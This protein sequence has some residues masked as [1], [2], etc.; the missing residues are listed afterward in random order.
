MLESAC[1]EVAEMEVQPER[2]MVR[3][4]P[5]WD[6]HRHYWRTLD[7]ASTVDFDKRS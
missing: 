6:E 5:V 2:A 7:G 4:R 1:F 3:A